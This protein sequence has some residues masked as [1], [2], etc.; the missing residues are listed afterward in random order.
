MLKRAKTRQIRLSKVAIGGDS[1]VTVQSMTK[2]RTTDVESTAYQINSLEIAGCEL[3]RLAVPNMDAALCLGKIKERIHIPMIADIHFDWK[4]ALEAVAQGVDGLRINPGNIGPLWK[5]QEVVTACKDNGIPIRI[6]VNGGSL[7]KDILTKYGHPTPEAIVESAERH[8]EI[9]DNMNFKEIKVSLKASNVPITIEAYRLFSARHDIPL[10]IGI[11]EA[12]IPET[13]IIKSAVGLGT[14]L[15][16]GI[17]D[18]MRVSLTS[19]PE[20]EVRVA[21]EILKSL[22]I[23]QRGINFISCPTCGRTRVNLVK[24]AHE[25]SERLK[26][27]KSTVTVAIMGCEVNGPGEAKEADYGIASGSG[28]GLL[29]KKGEVVRKVKESDLITA[30]IDLINEE[31]N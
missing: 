9:L 17:G 1:P 8:I 27:V 30:L 28:E 13:G 22:G 5:V 15:Y 20:E 21:Y 24:L 23:R 16:D 11:S 14:L 18:T 7:Q 10:H 26:S 3:I 29:F 12:G 31:V 4:L 25:A 2:T 19:E 6:G